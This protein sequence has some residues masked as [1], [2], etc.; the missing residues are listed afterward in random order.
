[1][2]KIYGAM[3]IAI[4]SLISLASL[5]IANGTTTETATATLETEVQAMCTV[6][7]TDIDFG[8]LIA[9]HT[10]ATEDT[11]VSQTDEGNVEAS[12]EIMGADWTDGGSN[13]FGVDYT[14]W[15]RTATDYDTMATLTTSFTTAGP[16][17]PTPQGIAVHLAVRIPAHQPPAYYTQTVTFQVTC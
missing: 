14:H 13:N 3:A 15:S 7:A 4:L 9:T 6:Q 2:E 16:L 11:G 17:P 12:L 10:S 8:T 5:A 1:L